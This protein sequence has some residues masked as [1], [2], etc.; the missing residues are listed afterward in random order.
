MAER[1]AFYT[2]ASTNLA[3]PVTNWTLMATN[4]FGP[5]GGFSFTNAVDS[6]KAQEFFYSSPAVATN[7]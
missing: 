3:L 1:F 2:L 7:I 6:G 5:G 4:Q